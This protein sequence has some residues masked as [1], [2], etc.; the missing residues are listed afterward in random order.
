[1]TRGLR[2][3]GTSCPLRAGPS[4]P[5]PSSLW[6][7]LGDLVTP[8]LITKAQGWVTGEAADLWSSLSLASPPNSASAFTLP[9]PERREEGC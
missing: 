8:D 2:P 9:V 1:M 5:G 6:W 4:D 3:P 7:E